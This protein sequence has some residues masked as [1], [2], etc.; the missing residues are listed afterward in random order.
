MNKKAPFLLFLVM[1][2]L[3]C[4]N[5][6][7]TV[8]TFPAP[9]WKQADAINEAA[10]TKEEYYDK[11]LGLLVGSAIGDAMGA[12]TEMWHRDQIRI[13]DGYVTN[14]T[15]LYRPDSPEGPWEDFMEAGSTTDDTRWK[16]LITKFL[17]QKENIPDS[18][19][20][21]DFANFLIDQYLNEMKALKGIEAFDPEPI[22]KQLKQMNWLQEWAKVAKPYAEGDIDKYS[23][24]RDRFYGGE[25]AC[26]GMLYAPMI[27]GVYPTNPNRAYLEA[28]RLGIFDIG[29]ARDITGLT[30]AMTARAMRPGVTYSEITAVCYEIDPLRYGNSRLVG[31]LAYQSYQTVKNIVAEAKKVETPS[32][33]PLE[34]FLGTAIE[35][36]QLDKAYELLDDHLQ[37]IPFHAGEIHLM[38]LAAIEFAEGDFQ[39][40]VEFAV[41]YGRD[42]D[43]VAA[44]TGA[45]LGAMHGFNKLPVAMR[46]KTLAVSKNII[47]IDLEELAREL[48]DAKYD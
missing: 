2:I 17:T 19:N 26:A 38:N 21:K 5:E 44:V 22:E 40:A 24:T 48:T 42:N 18:L 12:P 3:S 25:M 7:S 10:L 41:N 32:E 20:A 9:T 36:A 16:Y 34:G 1:S 15:T 47:R 27:G 31:R 43:T 8:E 28:F 35:L 11:I 33:K 39:K 23:Y 29:Y 30:A 46:E 13:Q 6:K 14:L 45:I 37:Q 4:S